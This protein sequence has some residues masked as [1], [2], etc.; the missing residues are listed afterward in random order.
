MSSFSS[1]SAAVKRSSVSLFLCTFVFALFWRTQ[2]RSTPPKTIYII[3]RVCYLEIVA[4][5]SHG[6]VYP[7]SQQLAPLSRHHFP[8]GQDIMRRYN[9]MFID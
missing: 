1:V 3:F 6:S 9:D 8:L 7:L 5:F 4:H 2:L